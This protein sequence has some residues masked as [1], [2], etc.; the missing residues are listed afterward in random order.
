LRYQAPM[1]LRRR[2][3]ARPDSPRANPCESRLRC[4]RWDL[5]WRS[6]D[7]NTSRNG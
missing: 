3:H 2:R 6:P 7:A 5:R 4:F 1:P